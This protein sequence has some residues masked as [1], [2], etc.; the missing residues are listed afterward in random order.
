MSKTEILETLK[1][2]RHMLQTRYKVDEISLFGSFVRDEQ[3]EASDIDVLVDLNSDASYFDLVR[4]G[5][6]LEEIFHRRVDVVLR[7]SL[8]PEIREA[9]LRERLIL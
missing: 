2:L 8:R 3:A 4:L 7:E 5:D 1:A 6:F 9:I